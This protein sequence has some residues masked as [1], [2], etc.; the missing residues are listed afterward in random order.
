MNIILLYEYDYGVDDREQLKSFKIVPEP[1]S[2]IC[3]PSTIV[4]STHPVDPTKN[5]PY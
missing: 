3:H 4:T 5:I 2:A 1:V